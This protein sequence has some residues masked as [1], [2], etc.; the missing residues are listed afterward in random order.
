MMRTTITME[1]EMH[2]LVTLY[3]RTRRITFSA[4]ICQ[5]IRRGKDAP[6][7]EPYIHRS[8]NGFPLFPPSAGGTISGELVKRLD[9][10]P[11]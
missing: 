4:A 6:Q 7:P 1:K 3:A 2:D 8:S 9:E 10:E 5:L 11:I